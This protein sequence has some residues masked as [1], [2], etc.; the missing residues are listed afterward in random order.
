VID[1]DR[2]SELECCDV[3]TTGRHSGRPHEVEIWFGVLDGALVVV[4]GNRE[5]ADWYRNL[6]ADPRV[7]VRIGDEVHDGVARIVTDPDE[8]RRVG[9]VMGAKYHYS[10]ASIGL[11]QQAWT[12]GVPAVVIELVEQ[13]RR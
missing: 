5:R 12:Y 2:Y 10:D 9:D 13:R 4:S 3:T 1:L 8:R 11:T 7:T 6:R